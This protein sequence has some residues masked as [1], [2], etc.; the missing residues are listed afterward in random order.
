MHLLSH[1]AAG[2]PQDSLASQGRLSHHLETSIY[3]QTSSQLEH[4]YSFSHVAH[5]LETFICRDYHWKQIFGH[6]FFIMSLKHMF[7][8]SAVH[9]ARAPHTHG[10]ETSSSFRHLQWIKMY[11]ALILK[12]FPALLI[13]SL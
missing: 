3:W 11:T 7:Y 1:T 6:Y 13:Q 9:I 5:S 12:V 2:L 4:H 8:L 10:W